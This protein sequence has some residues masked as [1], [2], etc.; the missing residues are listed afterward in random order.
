MRFDWLKCRSAQLQF[1]IYWAPG[2]ENFADFFTKNHSAAHH[3]ALRP[4]YLAPN[5]TDKQLSMQGCIKIL[6]SRLAKPVTLKTHTKLLPVPVTS[7]PFSYKQIIQTVKQSRP[8]RVSKAIVQV[9][10]RPP[11]SPTAPSK[12]ASLFDPFKSLAPLHTPLQA[13]HTKWIKAPICRYSKQLQT[14]I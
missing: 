5:S 12:T 3:K 2:Q 14:A 1:D 13:H 6:Q 9:Q 10:Q 4:I 11:A 8:T 7:K